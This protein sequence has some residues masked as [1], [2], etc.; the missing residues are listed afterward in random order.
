MEILVSSALDGCLLRRGTPSTANVTSTV[1]GVAHT[2]V[3]HFQER[4][5]RSQAKHSAA[6]ILHVRWLCSQS[7]ACHSSPLQ[8]LP[9]Q[10]QF[11]R[12][13]CVLWLSRREALQFVEVECLYFLLGGLS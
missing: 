8:P 2:L 9:P 6:S 7:S 10:P 12:G 4:G 1:R 5:A 3:L 13:G 11:S